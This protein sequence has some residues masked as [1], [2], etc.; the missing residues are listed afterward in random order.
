MQKAGPR[1]GSR[2]L[3]LPWSQRGGL[4]PGP[5]AG[6][7]VERPLGGWQ[8]CGRQPARAG[9]AS[10][11]WQCCLRGSLSP[12]GPFLPC[13]GSCTILGVQ[14]HQPILSLSPCRPRS[15]SR[16]SVLNNEGKLLVPALPPTL[17]PCLALATAPGPQPEGGPQP[18]S[19]TFPT[20]PG[21]IP[22]EPHV[23]SQ[24]GQKFPSN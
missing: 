19:A 9:G 15:G 23:G 3:P 21:H 13:L 1:L 24:I 17:I 20:C 22:W 8:M 2:N 18:S 12:P 4:G 10:P 11:G 6:P 7:L 14:P 16:S 5:S